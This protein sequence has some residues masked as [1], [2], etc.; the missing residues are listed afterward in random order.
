MQK[1]FRWV[2]Q[3]MV[4]MR[5]GFKAI[6][7][8]FA[9]AA[10]ATRHLAVSCRHAFT[11]A[12][13]RIVHYRCY[14]TGKRFLMDAVH[15]LLR[16]AGHDLASSLLKIATCLK[17]SNIG[18]REEAAHC[19]VEVM[20]SWH[21]IM[22][23]TTATSAGGG[24]E[25][26][27]AFEDEIAGEG[28]CR[29]H[30]NAGEMLLR[31]VECVKSYARD[32]AIPRRK[33]KLVGRSKAG[34]TESEDEE[35]SSNESCD[36]PILERE[37]PGEEELPLQAGATTIA[38]P[39]ESEE[40]PQAGSDG[41]GDRPQVALPYMYLRSTSIVP[42]LT[43]ASPSPRGGSH[44]SP[45]R[46]DRLI[47][48]AG[49]PTASARQDPGTAAVWE[50]CWKACKKGGCSPYADILP[51]FR[52]ILLHSAML[53][54]NMIAVNAFYQHE[55]IARALVAQQMDAACLHVRRERM[56]RSGSSRIGSPRQGGSLL[57]VPQF[58]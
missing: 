7:D 58:L 46:H 12:V 3:G 41:D 29:N 31:I 24:D 6:D 47:D 43:D 35:D 50:F 26:S 13:L 15:M 44:D 38:A 34:G 18:S 27:I 25:S 40:Q 21:S 22:T 45:R 49:D 30:P 36:S 8:H 48:E 53:A 33:N 37:I 5:L 11:E 1:I 23:L 52:P 9:D 10:A 55:H 16:V 32:F 14:D 19:I 28:W 56:M 2:S 20:A 17:H 57:A 39:P 4:A 51:F 54:R 42:V